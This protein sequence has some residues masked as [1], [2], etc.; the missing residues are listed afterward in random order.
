MAWYVLQVMTGKETEFRSLARTRVSADRSATLYIPTRRLP[1]RRGG[2]VR[3][4]DKPIFPGYLFANVQELLPTIV[5]AYR[6]VPGF[7]RWLGDENGPIALADKDLE[8]LQILMGYGELLG[9]SRAKF[10]P[11]QRIQVVDGPLKGLEGRIIRVDKRKQ[12]AR[13]RLDMYSDSFEVDFGYE[14]I[15]DADKEAPRHE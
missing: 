8:V 15:A 6:R 2:K 14:L 7:V 4:E 10:D 1:I 9:I 12:R 13:V 3:L 11:D 5:G